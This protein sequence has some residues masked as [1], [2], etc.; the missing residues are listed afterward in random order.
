MLILRSMK[1]KIIGTSHIAKQSVNQIKTLIKEWKPD[2]VAIELDR[3]RYNNLLS[4]KK[5]KVTLAAAKEIGF[6]GYIFAKMG[7]SLQ[8]KLGEKVGLIPGADMKAAI[9]EAK[10]AKTRIALID[11][12]IE[13]T[14]KEMSK[15]S[16]WEKWKL[17]GMLFGA[18]VFPFGKEQIDL[19]KVPSNKLIEE[20]MKK[21]KDKLPQ[22]YKVL[23]TDRNEYML[24]QIASLAKQHKDTK[25][26]VVVGAGHAK[27]L[28]RLILEEREY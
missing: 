18:T 7:G 1:I 21:F 8:Q 20:L 19:N 12:P 28:K 5:S 25:L 4:K 14:F 10:K 17:V 24:A 23:V 15:I 26:L 16:S 13:E 3:A 22:L 11:Q 27:D 9:K 2:I 6:A